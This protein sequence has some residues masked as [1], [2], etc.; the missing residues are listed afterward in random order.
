MTFNQ[1]ST[2]YK[3]REHKKGH[4]AQTKGPPNPVAYLKNKNTVWYLFF[5]V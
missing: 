4:A 3:N 2:A 5:P 1:V